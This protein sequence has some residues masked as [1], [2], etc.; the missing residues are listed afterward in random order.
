MNKR[1]CSQCGERLEGT[2]RFCKKCGAEVSLQLQKSK[3]CPVDPRGEI[4][5]NAQKKKT[6]LLSA[7]VI[8]LLIAVIGLSAIVLNGAKKEEEPL[9]TSSDSI[10]RHQ[11][12][13]WKEYSYDRNGQLTKTAVYTQDGKIK[14][15]TEYEYD[16]DGNLT[17]ETNYNSENET[18]WITTYEYDSDHQ[19]RSSY[20]SRRGEVNA[21][22]YPVPERKLYYN[23]EDIFT[24]DDVKYVQAALMEMGYTGLS[25]NGEFDRETEAA[26]MQFEAN[27]DL[28]VDGRVGTETLLKLIQSL[29]S[30]RAAH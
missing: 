1:R 3:D 13:S 18:C 22:V 10:V 19:L 23:A 9:P 16:T 8:C 28:E 12:G 25:L 30:W 5:K 20:T 6:I 7:A 14:H 17:Q 24:G 27:H 11:D 29:S 21:D 26:V 2:E 4:S 15:W